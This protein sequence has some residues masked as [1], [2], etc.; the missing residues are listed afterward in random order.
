MTEIKYSPNI[1]DTAL[2]LLSSFVVTYDERKNYF[3][4][5]LLFL[6]LEN[7]DAK[8]LLIEKFGKEEFKNKLKTVKKYFQALSVVKFYLDN[9]EDKN[10]WK[11]KPETRT[12]LFQQC[13]LVQ[14]KIPL[15][16]K[17][18]F[19]LLVPI[20]EN[21]NLNNYV[22]QRKHLRPVELVYQKELRIKIGGGVKDS[23]FD[24]RQ[25]IS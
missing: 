20:I 23:P 3:I 19:E 25:N 22:L 2:H 6:L 9:F 15:I 12:K 4:C 14:S 17:A 5:S 13:V 24:K 11:D 10:K 16:H 8:E 1:I 18:V 21:S 7:K